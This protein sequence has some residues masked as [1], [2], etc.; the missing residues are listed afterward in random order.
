MNDIGDHMLHLGEAHEAILE[1]ANSD[2]VTDQTC[3]A[4]RVIARDMERSLG[5]IDQMTI[6]VGGAYLKERGTNRKAG[7]AAQLF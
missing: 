1:I 7:S 3:S 6:N 5:T 4:L 2:G